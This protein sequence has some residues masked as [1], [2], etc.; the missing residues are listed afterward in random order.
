MQAASSSG[1]G[2]DGVIRAASRRQCSNWW[3]VGSRIRAGRRELDVQSIV[4]AAQ[5]E[6]R[7]REG[8]NARRADRRRVRFTAVA[9]RLAVRQPVQPLR[10][11][12]A[13]G[14]AGEPEFR[15]SPEDLR[16]IYVRG[17]SG[18]MVPLDAVH[19]ALHQGPDLIP[20]FN[21]SRPRRSTAA[22]RP[23]TVPASDRRDGDARGQLPE[24]YGIAWSGQA[25]EEKQA[26]GASAMVFVSASSWC[27]DPGGT[28]RVV[29]AAGSVI[30]AVPFGVLGALVPC[31]CAASRTTSTSRSAS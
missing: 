31:G 19:G 21:V 6:D 27:S 15:S 5:R 25:Y 29:V 28:V 1:P 23:A 22:R 30:T 26:G 17:R 11:N 14:A 9:V 4:A 24:G 16:S 7:S 13:G 20:R 18:E 3:P 2:P 10:A 12:L 8:G